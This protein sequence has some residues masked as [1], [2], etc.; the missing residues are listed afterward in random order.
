M[1]QCKISTSFSNYN[2]DIYQPVISEL[3]DL[4]LAFKTLTILLDGSKDQSLFNQ[5]SSNF[6]LVED[7]IIL[8]S[9]YPSVRPVFIS[10]PQ[11]ISIRDSYW[12]TLKHL[13]TCTC[14]HITLGWSHLRHMDLDVILKKWKA[15]GFPNLEYL[16]VN[17]LSFANN[18][19]TI[20]GMKLRELDGI[21]IQTD[22]GSKKATIS[23]DFGSIELSVI[24]FQK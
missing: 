15:G 4:Q 7:L 5:I 18:G 6:G 23:H 3:L 2:S 19:T 13:L 22:D 17:S 20:L 12:F 9:F 8:S 16:R 11:K 1:F 24:L 14:T 10:W 21:V